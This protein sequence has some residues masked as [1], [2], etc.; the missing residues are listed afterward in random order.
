MSH[1][2]TAA[3]TLADVVR[4]IEPG[5]LTNPT[6]CAEFDV[7]ELVHHL[8]YWGPSLEGA[9]R[10]EN[11]PPAEVSTTD[12]K[13]A[14]LAQLRRTVEAW[15]PASAWEGSTSMGP[16]QT[17]GE[18]IVGE[19][20]V[21]AW[22]LARATGQRPDLPDDLLA[23]T[24]DGIAAGADQGREMGLYGPEVPVPSDAPLLDRIL[25]LTGRDAARS[26]AY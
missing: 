25:G 21:H 24:Y 23:Y 15:T 2:S 13:G 4:A 11:V 16:A 19:L 17:V 14:L 5:Q 6:P 9:G 26:A 7:R 1:M 18:M 3:D 8:L 12:W 22:D 20:V 10:K